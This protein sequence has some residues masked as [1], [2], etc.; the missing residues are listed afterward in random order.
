MKIY[1]SFH[2]VIST[3][4]VMPKDIPLSYLSTDSYE[5][6]IRVKKEN[7]VSNKE[8]ITSVMPYETFD[9][10][11]VY[12]FDDNKERIEVADM[13]Q[14]TGD[15]YY[16]IPRDAVEFNPL[17]FSFHI[18]IKK[19]MQY[20]SS[21]NYNVRVACVDEDLSLAETLIGIFGDSSRRNLSP[22]N[23]SINNQD[24]SVY[25]LI[26]SAFSDNDF[27]IIESSDG[28]HYPGTNDPI[29]F[30]SILDDHTNVWLSVQSFEDLLIDRDSDEFNILHPTVYSNKTYVADG[31]KKHFD[32]EKEHS[33]FTREEYDYIN[34]FNGDCGIL[35]LEKKE[36][37]FII[38]SEES[39]LR[40]ATANIKLIYEMLMK[41]FLQSYFKTKEVHTWITDDVVDYVAL[42]ETRYGLRHGKFFMKDL[43]H[44]PDYEIGDE[45]LLMNAYVSSGVMFFGIDNDGVLLF[46]KV[47][48][49]TDPKKETDHV[50]V[51]TT[52]QTVMHYR[53]HSINKVE[54]ELTVEPIYT[55]TGNYIKIHV[56]KS[57]NLN[58][59]SKIDQT[60]RV[61]EEHTSYVLCC[62]DN[63]F[64]L[65]PEP[66]YDTFNDGL[67]MATIEVIRNVVTRNIDMR[68]LGGG[69]PEGEK[70]NYNLLDVS[71]IAGRP[72]RIGGAM[73]ITLPKRLEPYE[74]IIQD[75][76]ERHCASGDV[77]IILFE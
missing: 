67:K 26:N 43:L 57:T 69:L 11:D 33:H 77:P 48:A 5:T 31:Y 15:K 23:I 34:V 38:V 20:D 30:D 19:Q 46:Q 28:I 7:I 74:K 47:N 73:I 42:K 12:L 39:L 72:Y 29:D 59:D 52:R 25:S 37:G 17:R 58:I 71:H 10:P 63:M 60:L 62:K 3:D 14:R 1:P 45:Y 44:T 6:E 21:K 32:L 9:K 53:K 50:S 70:E 49:T 55:E 51:Y 22:T 75:A 8:H 66:A 40:N 4:K 68:I 56:F 13:L 18:S 16:F 54:T 24:V 36:K 35:V 41:I 76:V 27:V 61:P 65:I 2:E 64:K